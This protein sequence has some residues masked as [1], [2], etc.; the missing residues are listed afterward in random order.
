MMISIGLREAAIIAIKSALDICGNEYGEFSD[1]E[2]NLSGGCDCFH[3][4]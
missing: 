1:E 3:A 2:T 4:G